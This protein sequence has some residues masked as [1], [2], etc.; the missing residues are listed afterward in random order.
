[1]NS[2]AVICVSSFVSS[3]CENGV[4]GLNSFIRQALENSIRHAVQHI[5]HCRGV[6]FEPPV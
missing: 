4:A 2:R 1:M 5:D 6:K 3:M